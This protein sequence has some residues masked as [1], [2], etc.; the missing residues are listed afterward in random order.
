[1]TVQLKAPYLYQFDMEAMGD[2]L[3]L[4]T[5]TFSYFCNFLL[6]QELSFIVKIDWEKASEDGS[7]TWS[8]QPTQAGK[9]YYDI[10]LVLRLWY[11]G[12]FR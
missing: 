11:M 5:L 8:T 6:V 4:Q 9:T 1:M 10:S 3:D 7:K 12:V 2:V